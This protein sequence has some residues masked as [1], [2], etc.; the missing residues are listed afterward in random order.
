MAEDTVP[1]GTYST[2]QSPVDVHSAP[3]PA[4]S[5]AAL[6]PVDEHIAPAPAVTYATSASAADCVAPAPAAAC[7]MRAPV[8]EHTVP[9]PMDDCGTPLHALLAAPA[10]FTV[11]QIGDLGFVK[12]GNSCEFT[13]LGYGL[14][15]C[16]DKIRE[17]N[18]VDG[19]GAI[20]FNSV[21]LSQASLCPSPMQNADDSDCGR[22]TRWQTAGASGWHTNAGHMT[23]P[24]ALVAPFLL[25]RVFRVARIPVLRFV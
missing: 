8:S 5:Y 17:K 12:D 25:G 21:T 10:R 3:A 7:A 14:P 22:S 2:E 1:S 4:V 16:C 13:K 19:S 9:A 15:S 24:G 18:A 20:G 11:P 6:A 23:E